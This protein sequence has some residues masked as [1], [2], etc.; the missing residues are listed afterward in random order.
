M[1]FIDEKNMKVNE[2]EGIPPMDMLHSPPYPSK[3]QPQTQKEV[4]LFVFI[5]P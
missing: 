1:V 5:K 2:T 4:L 3:I